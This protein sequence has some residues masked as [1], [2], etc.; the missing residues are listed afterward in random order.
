[1]MILGIAWLVIGVLVATIIGRSAE[2]GR[3]AGDAEGI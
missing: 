3:V 1:M 2:L